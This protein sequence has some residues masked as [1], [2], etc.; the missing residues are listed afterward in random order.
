MSDLIDRQTAIDALQ[1]IAN[2]VLRHFEVNAGAEKRR[3]MECIEIIKQLPSAEPEERTAKVKKKR[4]YG[5]SSGVVGDFSCTGLCGN[6]DCEVV[7]YF[8]FC[9]KCGARLEWK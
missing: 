4:F 6:C 3:Y 9:P 1:V 5:T 7:E 8:A 2:D